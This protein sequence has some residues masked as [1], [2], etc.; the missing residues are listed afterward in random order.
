MENMDSFATGAFSFVLGYAE[1]ALHN[2]SKM[3]TV[4]PDGTRQ[5]TERTKRLE[6]AVSELHRLWNAW[7]GM[8]G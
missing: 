2:E 7:N 3:V 1:R 5:K 6:T 4:G 8:E